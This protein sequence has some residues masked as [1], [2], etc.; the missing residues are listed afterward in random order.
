[1]SDKPIV[2]LSLTQRE[3]DALWMVANNVGGLATTMRSVFSTSFH[4]NTGFYEKLHLYKSRNIYTV[5]SGSI[6]FS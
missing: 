6:I 1:M 2:T 5:T 3:V 4:K